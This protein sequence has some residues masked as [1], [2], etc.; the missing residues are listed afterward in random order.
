MTMSRK[1]MDRL[2]VPPVKWG[3]VFDALPQETREEYVKEL[4]SLAEAAS[5]M[6]GYF[7]K[8]QLGH[9]HKAAVKGSNKAANATRLSL[10]FTYRSDLDF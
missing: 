10:G 5:R 2:R 3:E 8:R 1:V 4:L 9:A 6:A 7:N